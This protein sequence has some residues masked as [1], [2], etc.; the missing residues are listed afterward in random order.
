MSLEEGMSPQ[1]CDVND[2][3]LMPVII[4]LLD[5]FALIELID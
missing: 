2:L 4:L 1:L 5:S 3:R